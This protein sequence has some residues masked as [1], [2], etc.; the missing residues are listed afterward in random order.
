M[1]WLTVAVSCQKSLWVDLNEWMDRW[2]DQLI[3]KWHGL[4]LLHCVAINVT[5]TVMPEP[6]LLWSLSEEKHGEKHHQSSPHP[7]GL[8]PSRSSTCGDFRPEH[9]KGCPR[10]PLEDLVCLLLTTAE[11]TTVTWPPSEMHRRLTS[12]PRMKAGPVC[13]TGQI[14]YGNGPVELRIPDQSSGILVSRIRRKISIFTECLSQVW[15]R[16][17]LLM[18][19][20]I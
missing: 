8:R 9:F 4:Y 1:V 11:S 13:I 20:T 5:Y 19:S 10:L 7:P 14:V 17:T 15:L 16:C 12:L 18:C 3:N 6:T 2:M